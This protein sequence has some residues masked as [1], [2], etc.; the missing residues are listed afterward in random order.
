MLLFKKLLLFLFL[1]GFIACQNKDADR[2]KNTTW[3]SGQIINPK[4]DYIIFSKGS[5]TLD[6]VKLD[7]NNFFLFRSEE[8]TPGLYSFRHHENQIMFLEPGDSLMLYLNTIDFDES[9]AYSGRGAE[10]NNLLM[11]FFL[12]N[13]TDINNLAKWYPLTAEEFVIK[14][15][16]TKRIKIAHYEEYKKKNKTSPDFNEVIQANLDYHYYSQ[17]EL[18]ATA[19]SV[20]IEEFPDSFFAYRDNIDFGNENLRFYYP[21]YRY[22]YRYLNNLAIQDQKTLG[23]SHNSDFGYNYRKIQLTDSLIPLE[24]LKNSFLRHTAIQY[25]LNADV[26]EE[27]KKFF[28][29]YAQMTSNKADIKEVQDLVNATMKLT[30]GNVVPDVMLANADGVSKLLSEV[31]NSPSVIFFWSTKYVAQYRNSH[32]RSAELK[33]KYPEYDF[34]GINTDSHSKSWRETITKEGYNSKSEFQLESLT[35]G[36]KT[37]VLNSLNKV[38][39]IDKNKKILE[40]NCNMFHHNFENILLENLNK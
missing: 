36:Q 31:I 26:A 3:I 10:R 4:V 5:E 25:I 23:S 2:K 16:S 40:G 32:I 11:D 29:T 35:E 17:K 8:I 13:E 33:S 34:I 39:L 24:T 6:T 37:L 15:D 28:D 20:K 12:S 1:I 27:Q 18:Y 19:N 21:Y 14:I 30:P 22:L 38:M 9:L 7:S